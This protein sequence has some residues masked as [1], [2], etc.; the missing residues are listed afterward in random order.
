MTKAPKK[1]R[2]PVKS[3]DS[4]VNVVSGLGTAKA[5]RSHQ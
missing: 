1:P 4:L 3:A 5:K 2:S